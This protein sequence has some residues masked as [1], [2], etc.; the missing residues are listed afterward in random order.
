MD[1]VTIPDEQ[2]NSECLP[3]IE[4]TDLLSYLVL[5]TSF[6]T[7][8]Q[9]KTYKSLEAYNFMVSGFITS[10][11]G[12]I[13]SGKHVVAGK[14]RHSQRMNDPLISVWV[15]AEKDGTVKSAHCLGCKAGLAESC[16]HVASV[17][18]YI[19]AWTRIR[20]KLTCTEVKCTWLL[21][22]FVKE[23][24]YA[25][26]RF[27]NLTSARKLKADLDEKIENLGENREA[28]SST[29]SGRKVTVQVPTQTEM[30]NFYANLNKSRIKPVA[31]SLIEPYSSQFVSQSR[32][33]P[34]IPD[35]FDDEN[36]K[37]SYTD[38]LKKCFSVEICLSSEEILQ[39]ERDTHSNTAST[40]FTGISA[41]ALINSP[42]PPPMRRLFEGGA[43]SSNNCNWQLKSLLHLGQIVI[44][45]RI[46]LH[47]EQNVITFRTLLHLGPFI[48]FRPST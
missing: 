43:Y 34:T 14:V 41:A 19:E 10:I 17:L 6:Y 4:A 39:I 48:T 27:I 20:G 42:T 32:S 36:L 22:S 18:F 25:K 46:L 44:T 40:V 45:F 7:K 47:L 33:I 26:M 37:L 35:L 3:P 16:S 1:P 15:I 21:P 5:E 8:Q 13:V 9:F 29:G 24:P 31:L 2:F 23:V 12:C 30:D 38:L 11:Q 28:T